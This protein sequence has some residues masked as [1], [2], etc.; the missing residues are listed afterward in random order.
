MLRMPG[1]TAQKKTGFL[2]KQSRRSLQLRRWL[3]ISAASSILI[4]FGLIAY[5]LS[6]TWKDYDTHLGARSA[7]ESWLNRKWVG[8]KS[9]D[10]YDMLLGLRR[11]EAAALRYA[12]GS[13]S[14]KDLSDQRKQVASMFLHFAP[15]SIISTDLVADYSSFPPAYQN[16]LI[17]L[18]TT[19]KF[20][21]GL[22][23][24]DAVLESADNALGDWMMF[25]QDT[26]RV[27]YELRDGMEG[28][29]LSFRP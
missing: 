27:E 18:N 10:S 7:A 8:Y 25:T 11:L 3:T 24:I 14:Q 9:I 12:V 16:A 21:A 20:E 15:G 29:I 6:N 23:T 4:L 1:K 13:M 28:T 5:Q 17:F 22:Q 2:L 26:I 19:Q